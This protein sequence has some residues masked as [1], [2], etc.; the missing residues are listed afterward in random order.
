[1][2]ARVLLIEHDG[3]HALALIDVKWRPEKGF[4]ITEP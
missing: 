1:M 4:G 2:Y 3:D